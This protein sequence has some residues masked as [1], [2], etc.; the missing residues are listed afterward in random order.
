MTTII[1]NDYALAA[2]QQVSSVDQDASSVQG[3]LWTSVSLNGQV[4][5]TISANTFPVF[6]V[7]AD[8]TDSS[9]APRTL[10][11]GATGGLSVNSSAT[12]VYAGAIA[13]GGNAIS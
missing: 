5:V 13:S 9:G 10:T 6:A 3:S 7:R 2:G 1:T 8:T 11:I 4:L 12:G